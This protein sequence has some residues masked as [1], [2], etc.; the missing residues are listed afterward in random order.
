M[1]CYDQTLHYRSIVCSTVLSN[2]SVPI[3]YGVLRILRKKSKLEILTVMLMLILTI[4]GK[5]Q[6]QGGNRNWGLGPFAQGH[7]RYHIIVEQPA[8]SVEAWNPLGIYSNNN[9]IRRLESA[10]CTRAGNWHF[11]LLTKL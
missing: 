7:S 11:V 4:T 9:K 5:S 3:A 6:G 8:S 1:K 2:L 10:V